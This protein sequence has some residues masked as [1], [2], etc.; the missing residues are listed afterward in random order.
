MACRERIFK[1]YSE[2]IIMNRKELEQIFEEKQVS[3]FDYS[4]YGIGNYES[5]CLLEEKDKWRVVFN[6]RGDLPRDFQ[7]KMK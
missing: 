6:S 2:V 4:L 3:E 7:T 1:T 5:Y